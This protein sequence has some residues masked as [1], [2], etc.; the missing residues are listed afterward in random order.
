MTSN[1]IVQNQWRFGIYIRFL[2]NPSLTLYRMLFSITV[3][4]SLAIIY[5]ALYLVPLFNIKAFEAN[6]IP[7]QTASLDTI[8][9]LNVA[10]LIV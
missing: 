3:L 1:V 4:D 5:K 7:L 10:H 6:L 2:C 9:S 8:L